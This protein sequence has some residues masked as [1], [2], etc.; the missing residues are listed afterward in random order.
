[1]ELESFY[2]SISEAKKKPAILIT[3]PF[4]KEFI[5]QLSLSSFPKPL[6]EYY[7]PATLEMKYPDLLKGCETIFESIKVGSFG[8]LRL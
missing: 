7:N 6:M 8:H 2:A 3:P 1:M 4:A 5:P